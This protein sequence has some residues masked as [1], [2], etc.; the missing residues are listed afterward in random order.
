MLHAARYCSDKKQWRHLKLINL[1]KYIFFHDNTQITHISANKFPVPPLFV[2]FCDGMC[3]GLCPAPAVLQW[4]SQLHLL[5]G[6]AERRREI[7]RKR[8]EGRERE[9]TGA[10]GVSEQVSD[11]QDAAHLHAQPRALWSLHHCPCPT[12]WVESCG[13]VW[14]YLGAGTPQSE[15]WINN[16]HLWDVF[17][18]LQPLISW[19]MWLHWL[20]S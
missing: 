4:I 6:A 9:N 10:F 18:V 5:K 19:R 15:W 11:L 16:F 12:R 7:E 14:C 20:T 17:W 13:A 8:E 3:C 1:K 2:L